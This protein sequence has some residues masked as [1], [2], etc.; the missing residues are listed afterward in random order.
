MPPGS[1]AAHSWCY[2]PHGVLDIAC[3]K[4]VA[5][6]GNIAF[7]FSGLPADFAI[8]AQAWCDLIEARRRPDEPGVSKARGP[9]HRRLCPRAKPDRRPRPLQGA[10]RDCDTVHLIMLS[11]VSD[12]LFRPE[13]MKKRSALFQS[14]AA[15]L[16]GITEGCKFLRGV[17]GAYP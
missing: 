1:L 11:A 4:D 9:A 15:L 5:N 13:P 3:D 12:I 7:A 17:A 2:R 10:R 14:A 6:Q 8:H 16:D